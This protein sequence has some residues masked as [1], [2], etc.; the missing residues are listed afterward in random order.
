M[1][2]ALPIFT[3][4]ALVIAIYNT[5]KT[6]S[7]RRA[8]IRAAGIW[9]GFAI[10]SLELLSIFEA[11]NMLTLAVSWALVLLTAGTF[12]WRRNAQGTLIL[13]QKPGEVSWLEI[14]LIACILGIL[15]LTAVVAWVA[16][17]QAIDTLH[18]QMSRVAH[19][20]QNQSIHPY[21]TGIEAQNSR[22]P[23]AQLMVLHLYV[24][25]GSD[26]L[27][28]FIQWGAFL[29]CI[30]AASQLAKQ[31]GGTRTSQLVTALMTATLPI[32]ITQAS[33][34]MTDVVVAFWIAALAVEILAVWNHS[35]SE[36]LPWF[37][38]IDSVIT[39]TIKPT[40]IPYLLPFVVLIAMRLVR[41]KSILSAA[42][43]V[44]IVLLVFLMLSGGHLLRTLQ[45]YGS[46]FNPAEMRIH[47]NGM[48]N[49]RG[50]ISNFLRN[51]GLQLSSPFPRLNYEIYRLIV[52]VHVKLGMDVND[53]LTTAHGYF[54]INPPDTYETGSPNPLQM[55]FIFLSMGVSLFSW[56]R[57]SSRVRI[58]IILG[59]STFFL[60]S[61]LFKWQIWGGRYF[62][63]FFVLMLPVS[64]RIIEQ[65]APVS[66]LALLALGFTAASWSWL[67]GVYS[68]PLIA[69]TRH[70]VDSIL[71]EDRHH[72]YFAN[73]LDIETAYRSMTDA[74]SDAS[75]SEI[76]LM[77]S[78]TSLEYPLWPLLGAPDNELTIE[79]IEYGTPSS[80]YLEED[81][82][83]CAVICL[84]CPSGWETVRGLPLESSLDGF[85]LFLLSQ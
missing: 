70:P 47:Q 12:L 24:L 44:G 23:G 81:F 36:L 30:L 16:P 31:F 58:F 71:L 72:L 68:R 69:Q 5:L 48:M 50:L 75:C 4:I 46:L 78:G 19:W 38:A 84:H 20:S 82:Q 60:F 7:L 74:I 18:Y 51:A 55:V 42:R 52:G 54:A 53:P 64:V 45:T 2:A 63:P 40:A 17:P 49:V 37:I 26:R 57:L 22:S 9:S 61:F 8:F 32:A 80:M 79:W 3:F 33:S 65:V 56:R 62:I 34:A 83:P 29:G 35:P 85:R 11:V 41:R 76:G 73:D 1:F 6:P 27:V 67:V 21:A 39:Y 14:V 13:P 28:N 77:L 66:L 59:L 15:I 43:W 25:A 10:L